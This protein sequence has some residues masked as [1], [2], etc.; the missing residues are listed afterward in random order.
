MDTYDFFPRTLT[1]KQYVIRWLI[2]AAITLVAMFVYVGAPTGAAVQIAA[3]V[4]VLCAVAAFVYNIFGLS[5]PRLRSVDIS[6]WTILLLFIPLGPLIMFIICVVA[7]E[8][9]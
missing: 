4:F 8:K 7:R 5:I 2:M 9:T 3:V 1:R 6:F